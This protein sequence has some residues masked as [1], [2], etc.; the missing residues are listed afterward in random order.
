MDRE[1]Q[2]FCEFGGFRLDT[3]KK[4]LWHEGKAVSMPLKEI[5]LLCVLIANK[6]EL[7][8]KEE[9]LDKV[10]ED[11]F[12]EESNLSRHIYLLRKTFKEFGENED[13]IE[14]IPRRGYRFTGS[15]VQAVNS[16][17]VVERR[18]LT[19][20]VIEEIDEPSADAKAIGRSSRRRSMLVTMLV[21]ALAVA[22]ASGV[23]LGLRPSVTGSQKI[24]S[25][26]VLPLRSIDGSDN[27]HR[28]LGL[29]DILITRLSG[30]KQ[31]VV[32]P[33]SVV[34]QYE[35]Q[36]GTATDI[37]QRL[38]VDA[39]LEGNIFQTGNGV[40]VTMRLVSV[41]DGKTVWS[42]EFDKPVQDELKLQ[43]EI[44]LRVTDALALNLDPQEK[45]NLTKRYTDNREAYE[46]YLLG[47]FY[48]DKRDPTIYPKALEQFQHAI[49]LDQNYALAY[50]G[51]ADVYSMQAN[52]AGDDTRDAL[53][54]RAKVTLMKALA[55][56][57]E[58]GEAHTSL[59]WIKR[60]HEWDW[61]GSEKEFKRAIEL[62]PN[63]Y[64]AHMWYSLLLITMGRKDEAL[65]EIEKARELA[66]LNPIVINN[67]ASVMYRLQDNNALLPIVEQLKELG[68][69]DFNVTVLYSQIYLRMGEYEKAISAINDFE[70]RNNGRPFNTLMRANLAAA[71]A[72]NGQIDKA[73][74]I[75]KLLEKDAATSSEASFHLSLAL[76]DMGR[77]DEAI[78]YLQKCVDKHDD[79]AVWIKVEPRFDKLR[80]DPRFQAILKKMNL[81]DL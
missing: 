56:D 28:G 75:I 59:A 71:Y 39:V 47:R 25:L 38:G 60:I 9:L 33:T 7:V 37:G 1:S 55:I 78:A 18:A 14:N 23:Y 12:V 6:G 19:R 74:P 36:T 40:R 80:S 41:A 73:E 79:R 42:G 68:G 20:T 70:A 65:F 63:Y 44:A 81:S 10:W 77:N 50:S 66:P 35:G 62:N 30:L 58:L 8:T 67:Y 69:R 15:V 54:E 52:D 34:A 32:Q 27:S 16:E 4:S 5:E 46:S 17:V 61:E 13:L 64:N 3:R 29:A 76:A 31:L 72:L 21:G 22:L 49:D 51:L 43:N 53:Y 26:A 57:D 2:H 24:R 11:S 48:F 45:R